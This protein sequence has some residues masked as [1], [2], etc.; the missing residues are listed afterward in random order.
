L[1]A[2]ALTFADIQLDKRFC[3]QRR[4][5]IENL[6]CVGLA[7]PKGSGMQAF[8]QLVTHIPN[9]GEQ[10]VR[11]YGYYSNRARGDRKKKGK[12]DEVPAL[13]ESEISSK[14]LRRSWAQLIRKIYNADPLLCP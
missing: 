7:P 3:R 14:Q 11:Y 8:A 2:I 10:M 4:Q 1:L 9:R 6:R 5:D 13:M 12:D